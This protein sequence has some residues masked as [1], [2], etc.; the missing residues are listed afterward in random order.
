MAESLR[1]A[2]RALAM[3]PDMLVTDAEVSIVTIHCNLAQPIQYNRGDV[4][5]SA[6]LTGTWA[7]FLASATPAA[8]DVIGVITEAKLT[9]AGDIVHFVAIK[10]AFNRD[11]IMASFAVAPTAPEAIALHEVMIRQGLHLQEVWG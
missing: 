1:T 8:T 2:A 3:P 10:G 7:K 4:V 9:A 11:K 5:S 6:T